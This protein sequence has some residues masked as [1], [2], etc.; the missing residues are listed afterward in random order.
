MSFPQL[1]DYKEEGYCPKCAKE[2]MLED[3]VRLRVL[4]AKSREGRGV[5]DRLSGGILHLLFSNGPEQRLRICYQLE[6]ING[7]KDK[8]TV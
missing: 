4:F 5:F 3:E 8:R 1:Y 2:V 7:G 6:R